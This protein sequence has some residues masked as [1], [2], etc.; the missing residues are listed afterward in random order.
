MKWWWLGVVSLSM[1]QVSFNVGPSSV[2]IN[3]YL[4][5][6]VI[7]E[8]ESGNLPRFPNGLTGS[9]FELVN[10]S[11]NRKS[12]VTIVNGKVSQR[13]VFTYYLKPLKKGNVSL[14]AQTVSLGGKDYQSRA[15]AVQVGDE[16]RSVSR[17][18]RGFDPFDDFFGRRNRR[19]NAPAEIYAVAEIPKNTYYLGE[20]I[21]FKVVIYRTPGVEI[22]SSG[23]SM[24]LP[25]F[26]HFWSEEVENNQEIK[27][28]TRDN[29]VM[30]AIVV[31]RRELFASKSG[32]LTIPAASFQLTV[33]VSRGLLAD[34]QTVKRDTKAID[35]TIKPLPEAGK[36]PNFQ[37]M[38][39]QFN[40]FGELDKDNIA[41]GESA[42][43]KV[44]VKGRGNFNALSELKLPELGHQFEVFD[45]GTPKVEKVG[46]VPSSKTWVFALVP[47][48]EG[49]FQIE[50]PQ[51][52]YFDIKTKNLQ[53]YQSANNFPL[54]WKAAK[55]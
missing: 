13:V 30:E 27:R 8:G 1:A 32:N 54:L 38:V 47:K 51:I 48:R 2:A 19:Q 52:S 9:D 4:Q 37:G 3:E 6:Q 25:E 43:F 40:V 23:S 12:S 15:Y 42:S 14:P 44:E 31:D 22:S 35:V 11:P 20:P 5:F 34:W 18:S 17:S 41:V 55:P 28:V 29:K 16:N 33:A 49:V 46:G 39:G 45:G 10:S 53:D 24:D 50:L 26:D 21:P 36:P 7:V